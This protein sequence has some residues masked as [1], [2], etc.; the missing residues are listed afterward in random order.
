MTFN[1][2][3]DLSFDVIANPAYF[4]PAPVNLIDFTEPFTTDTGQFTV[5]TDGTPGTFAFSGGVGVVTHTGTQSDIP[6][7]NSSSFTIPQAFISLQ[8]TQNGTGTSG[9]D[10]IA[11]GIIKD[12]SNYLIAAYDRYNHNAAIFINVAGSWHALFTAGSKTWTAPYKIGLS[13]VGNSVCFWVDTGSGWT[14]VT[15]GDVSSYKDFRTSGALSG[16]SAGILCDSNNSSVW[17]FDNFQCGRFGG[18]GM[19]DM[20]IVT[21]EDGTPYVSGTTIQFTATITDPIG[22][23]A[24]H[25]PTGYTGVF[26]LDLSDNSITQDAVIMISRDGKIYNDQGCHIIKYA[27]GNRRIFISTWGNGF[28]GT[29][30][31]LYGLL[32]SG[33]VL[34]GTNVISGLSALTLPN[35]NSGYGA[36]DQMVVYDSANSR[37]L[38]S[39]AITQST[40]WGSFG[41]FY[42]ALA[43][44]SDLSTFYAIGADS[45]NHNWEGC[46]ILSE[47]GNFW[48][49][50][51]G[52]SGSGNS[53][54]VYD[55]GLNYLGS[56]DAVFSGGSDTL[57]HPM[58]FA[59]GG[60]FYLLTFN[61]TKYG[62][63]SFTWGKPIIEKDSIY[64]ECT[65]LTVVDAASGA[66]NKNRAFLIF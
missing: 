28:G 43:Y 41:N 26:T 46:K 49:L 3:T 16:Y 57:P 48:V 15:G 63:N 45:A 24:A 58:V 52:P 30:Q 33:D 60:S 56:L 47:G 11:V 34:S 23:N 51:G 2:T 35:I 42:A 12:A 13:L 6:V 39:Y 62:S 44:S 29:I 66:T 19:R 31:V 61:N 25:I 40:A 21:N 18:V 27:G 10:D 38:I 54:R 4:D 22:V 17:K 50:V 14:Y 59:Y 36:Y 64:S 20:T 8:I 32:T 1:P 55:S 53:S 9:Y 37:W 7:Y 65:S 5:L